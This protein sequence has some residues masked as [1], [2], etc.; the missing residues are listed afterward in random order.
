MI[1]IIGADGFVGASLTRHIN[2][3]LVDHRYVQLGKEFFP[4][5]RLKGY[6]DIGLVYDQVIKIAENYQESVYCLNLMS[7]A[8]V[9]FCEANKDISNFVN[10][11]FP[12]EL[13]SR[14]SHVRNIRLVSFSSNA[15]Y[16][17]DT[18]LYNERSAFS[19][20]NTYGEQKARLDE[21][22]RN[23]LAECIIFRPT[24]LFGTPPPGTRSNPVFDLILK[25][26][27]AQSVKLVRDLTV[28]FGYVEDMCN[29][30][31]KLICDNESSGEYNFGGPN[32]LSR[33][34]LG[35]EIYRFFGVNEKLLEPCLMDDFNPNVKR[36]L[37]TSFDCRRFDEKFN[38][39]RTSILDYLAM[40]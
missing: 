16:G 17:G 14:L 19:P 38:L 6:D 31:L 3:T 23:D 11:T 27:Q 8:N 36:P 26:K 21:F 1:I 15:V 18:P 20:V 2:S 40:L 25:A 39:K 35:C 28:N 5:G 4:N 34:K 29:A 13:F 9:D 24:T 22:I 37:D 10:Y 7:A 12:K 30:L 32:N 33:Y